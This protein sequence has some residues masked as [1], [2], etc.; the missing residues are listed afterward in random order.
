QEEIAVN[1][2]STS[3]YKAMTLSLGAVLI[4]DKDATPF[5]RIWCCFEESIAVE[6][7]KTGTPL[8][9][10]VAATDSSN[11]A[12]VITDG[13]AA[14]EAR[15]MPL[16]GFLAKSLREANFPTLLAQK[17][18]GIDI[19]KAKASQAEDKTR[20]L[21][22]IR[23]PHARTKELTEVA[24]LQDRNYFAVNQALAA[25][26]ALALWF[27]FVAQG[28]DTND[29][30]RALAADSSRH[31]VELSFTG[32]RGFT[33]DSLRQLLRHLPR[34]LRTLR[35]DLGFS[36]I[37]SWDFE[38]MPPLEQLTLRFTGSRLADVSG[39]PRMLDTE[40]R[41]AQS[42]RSLHLWFSNLP[43]LVELG[44]WEPLAKLQ[45]EELVLQLDH[46]GQVLP[47][48][49]QSL[50]D[51][52]KRLKSSQ[53]GLDLRLM[54]EG[55]TELSWHSWWRPGC[56][57]AIQEVELADSKAVD[58]V[59]IDDS[60]ESGSATCAPFPC[61]HSSCN[62]FHE[63]MHGFCNKHRLRRHSWKLASCCQ[64]A[65]HWTELILL[66]A[67]QAASEI[68]R[69]IAL[70]AILLSLYPVACLSMEESVGV[71]W[72]VTCTSLG[73]TV[74]CSLVTTSLRLDR[75]RVQAL[76][77]CLA[78]ETSY[79]QV[80][81]LPDSPS[82]AMGS[83][84]PAQK[85]HSLQVPTVPTMGCGFADPRDLRQQS[86]DLSEIFLGAQRHLHLLRKAMNLALPDATVKMKL[87]TS[88][89]DEEQQSPQ[90]VVDALQCKLI[91]KN[92][93]DVQQ[94]FNGLKDRIN[95]EEVSSLRIAAVRDTFA[96]MNE[97]SC[98]KCCQV[99]LEVDNYY[100]SVFL[101]DFNLT[102]LENQR[103]D[104]TKLAEHFGLLDD[105]ISKWE[106]SMRLRNYVPD[107]RRPLVF[108]GT[109]LLQIVSLVVSLFMAVQYF[110][111][112]A[113]RIR[114]HLPGFLL[115]ALLLDREES[116]ETI[117]QAT[118]LA[119]PYLVLVVV[120]IQQLRR[121]KIGKKRPQPTQV[122]YEKY[123]GLR[124]TYYPV[125]VAVLQGFTV[126]VQAFGKIS[127]LSGLVTFAQHKADA[128]AIRLLT[129]GFWMFFVLLCWNSVYPLVLLVFPTPWTRIG[130]ALTDAV[131]DLGYILTYL[132]MVLVAMLRLQTASDAWGNFGEDLTL[133]FSNR[134]SPVFAFP[135]DFLG[136]A[137]VYTNLA[138][139]CCVA[140][141]LQR[142]NWNLPV[143]SRSQRQQH[144]CLPRLFG[145]FL[146]MGLLVMLTV[147]VIKQEGFPMTH[148]KNMKCFPCQCSKSAGSDGLQVYSCSLAA[149]LRQQQ[150]NLAGKN[151]TSID[152]KALSSLG[153]RLQRLSLSNNTL[154]HLPP[155][156]F[157]GLGCLEQLDLTRTKLQELHDDAF[158][159]LEK[160]K[161]LTMSDNELSHLSA[162]VL[163][164]MP[165][166]EQ[167]L[168]GGK[169]DEKT[170]RR[171]V[172]GNRITEL[173][174]IFGH[175]AALQ[176]IDFSEN[177]LMQ[178]DAAA[179][180]GL[181]ALKTLKLRSNKMI[182]IPAV[183][184]LAK[185]QTLE[186]YGNKIS[187]LS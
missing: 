8:L 108:A 156:L 30:L 87:L 75:M 42:L 162:M 170:H 175:N 164:Q 69:P 11:Q 117:L 99:V 139:A 74:L 150:V 89:S 102:R 135:T 127:L 115:D 82:M 36:G 1:P 119:L 105:F 174:A 60:S 31:V 172:E 4:L 67:M 38:E 80:L 76:N 160:L 118:C 15:Q 7:R 14:A 50:Y 73:A 79:S 121:W 94:S 152:P 45:L 54:I 171:I 58:H 183:Q 165:L 64:T 72:A 120:F 28:H 104:V 128:S 29:L 122:L 125:K 113:D 166:L 134:I 154:I 88:L 177:Q 147:L 144:K 141:V 53:R 145:A 151:I 130:A 132:G 176:V 93:L 78:T 168:L 27:G 137:A 149:V 163:R 17:G 16:L 2:R 106:T 91:C 68:E 18:L 6:E 129:A 84:F 182:T 59:D 180:S 34:Q 116:G 61:S 22:C 52:V 32:C 97:S 13:L 161:L 101:M 146:S 155:N 63:N 179:F 26:F 33:N 159:G 9:L 103:S 140:H 49:K 40:H 25:H 24:P 133:S 86:S 126:L 48:A 124:G 136:Y 3:F 158:R 187:R 107:M 57:Q 43:S 66:F 178:I 114:S 110:L 185:L 70:A 131:L 55:V 23:M 10:D 173:G 56:Q 181:R 37:E 83:S 153:C 19:S 46:C 5:T 21:N 123:F 81:Q 98:H 143:Q 100:A 167:L 111:R 35:L 41:L 184:G 138:H 95:S 142:T 51:C 77:L 109:T 169:S 92:M 62:E 65:W 47:E 71:P 85:L 44:S 39:L 12:Y 112:Y 96:E 90:K 148:G 157:A 20:I 186:L